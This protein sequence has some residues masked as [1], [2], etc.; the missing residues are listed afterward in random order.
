MLTKKTCWQK[1][2]LIYK[3]WQLQYWLNSKSDYTQSLTKL[4]LW[5]LNCNNSNCDTSNYDASNC[6][7]FNY[8]KKTQIGTNQI[9][10]TQNRTK[11]ELWQKLNVWQLELWQLKLWQLKFWQNSNCLNFH[12]LDEMY[13]GKPFAILRWFFSLWNPFLLRMDVDVNLVQPWPTC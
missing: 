8:H 9:V 2:T 7:N 12:H 4:Q 11:P 5:Q 13:S 10:T 6:D 3:L 1:K